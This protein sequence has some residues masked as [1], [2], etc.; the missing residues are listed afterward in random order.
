MELVQ[1]QQR[2]DPDLT[3]VIDNLRDGTL[4]ESYSE[5]QRIM[6]QG[7]KGDH[8]VD[9]ILYYESADVPGRHCLVVPYHLKEMNTMTHVFP[10]VLP[11]GE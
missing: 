3:N 10:D 6:V 4:S 9:D 5:A 8:V 2:Q 7:K 1:Q 11:Q